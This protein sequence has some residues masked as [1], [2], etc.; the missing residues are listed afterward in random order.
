MIFFFFRLE[1]FDSFFESYVDKQVEGTQTRLKEA[2]KHP[3]KCIRF[4]EDTIRQFF[5]KKELYGWNQ[6]KNLEYK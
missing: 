1:C 3:M 4:E 2:R 6:R 5:W